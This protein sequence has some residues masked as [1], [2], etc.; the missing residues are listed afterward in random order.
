[1][2]SEASA[3]HN[4]LMACRACFAPNNHYCE[5]GRD[6]RL[7]ADAAFIA[8][9]PDLGQRRYWRSLEQRQNPENMA[10]LDELIKEKFK[11]KGN[12]N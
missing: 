12:G 3:Y 2:S 10:R 11:E 4:H 6:L 8:S 9:K 1:M 7:H 5:E